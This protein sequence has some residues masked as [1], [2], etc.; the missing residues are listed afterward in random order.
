MSELEDLNLKKLYVFLKLI[1][2]STTNEKYGQKIDRILQ[3]NE[4]NDFN[5]YVPDNLNINTLCPGSING[6]IENGLRILESKLNESLINSMATRL[7]LAR[8]SQG[9]NLWRL[10]SDSN[11]PNNTAV[12]VSVSQNKIAEFI[13]GNR[14]K[15]NLYIDQEDPITLNIGDCISIDKHENNKIENILIKIKAFGQQVNNKRNFINIFYVPYDVNTKTFEKNVKGRC[16]SLSDTPKISEHISNCINTWRTIKKIS[17]P[18]NH[19]SV[20]HGTITI[21]GTILKTNDERFKNKELRY[22]ETIGN[23]YKIVYENR[24][25]AN[26]IFNVNKSIFMRQ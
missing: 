9:N 1:K 23:S 11:K 19:S 20:K 5:I 26:K 14:T 10:I 22:L 18:N 6:D 3:L 12:N 16:I 25:G 24:R 13:D 15:I 4:F 21:N 7:G 17:C 8:N 2:Q